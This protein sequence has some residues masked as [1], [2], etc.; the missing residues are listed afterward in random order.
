MISS[1]DFE[2]GFRVGSRG[3]ILSQDFHIRTSSQNLLRISSQ[4]HD[5]VSHRFSPFP[6]WPSTIVPAQ[7]L[8]G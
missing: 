5:R 2:F 6:P 3:K 8:G 7:A 4:D 1:Q